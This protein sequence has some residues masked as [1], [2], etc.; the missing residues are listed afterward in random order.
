MGLSHGWDAEKFIAESTTKT[1]KGDDYSNLCIG[2]DK[3]HVEV[4]GAALDEKRRDRRA[5]RM[6][7]LA[8]NG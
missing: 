8:T 3:F 7:V 1:P 2:C 6:G 5:Q 4:L